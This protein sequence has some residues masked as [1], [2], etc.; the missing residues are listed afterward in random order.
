MTESPPTQ[1]ELLKAQLTIEQ[2]KLAKGK[3][4]KSSKARAAPTS[5]QQDSAGQDP[6][7]ESLGEEDGIS[8]N[9]KPL[10]QLRGSTAIPSE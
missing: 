4:K 1:A 2:G 6:E 10:A 3:G 8:L 7:K 5:S 9:T